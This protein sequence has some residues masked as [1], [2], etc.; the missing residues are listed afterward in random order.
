MLS[1][2]D[3]LEV[4]DINLIFFQEMFASKCK[5]VKGSWFLLALVGDTHLPWNFVHKLTLKNCTKT[6]KIRT[7]PVRNSQALL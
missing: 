1:N 7:V 5:M 6:H 3:Q 2:N 4:V